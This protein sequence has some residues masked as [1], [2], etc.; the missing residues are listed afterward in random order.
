MFLLYVIDPKALK[1]LLMV[2]YVQREDKINDQ[3]LINVE[4]V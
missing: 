2:I 4:T 1:Y 3:I